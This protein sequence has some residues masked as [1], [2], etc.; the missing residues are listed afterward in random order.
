MS[1]H[2]QNMFH[3]I[4]IL[5]PSFLASAVSLTYFAR[6]NP[7]R[8]CFQN[9]RLTEGCYVWTEEHFIWIAYLQNS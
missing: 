5:G 9:G 8:I 3:Y 7:I 2:D 4:G 1:K 6:Q